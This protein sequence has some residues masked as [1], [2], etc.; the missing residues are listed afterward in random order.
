[1][2]ASGAQRLWSGLDCYYAATDENDAD[3]KA[4]LVLQGNILL[5]AYEQERADRL[6]KVALEPFPGQYVRIVR[7]GANVANTLSLKVETSWALRGAWSP[8]RVISEQFGGL[9]TRYV[10]ALDAPLFS[11]PIRPLRLG[12]G[13]PRPT[14]GSPY[15]PALATLDDRDLSTLFGEYDR[16]GG[17]PDACAARNWTQFSDRMKFIVNLFRAGQQDRNLYRPLPVA[18][19]RTLNLDLSDAH[20]NKLRK[21]GDKE[22]DDWIRPHVA[23]RA[24]PDPRHYVEDLVADGFEDLLAADPPPPEGKLPDWADRSKLWAGQKFFRTFGLEVGA[25][26]FSASLPISY[27]AAHGARVL[28]TT[29]ALVSDPRRRLAETGQM[30]LDAMASD[31]SSKPPLDPDTRAFAAAHGVRLFHGAVRH[32]LRTDPTVNW[33]ETRLGVPIN[34]EDLVGTLAVFT[35]AVI[36]SLDEMGVTVSVRDRDNYFHLWLVMGHLLGIDYDRLFRN[37]PPSTEQPLTY[38]DMQLIAR[39]IFARN[40]QASP[41]GRSLMSALLNV[42]EGSMPPFLK[43]V[44]RALTR[45]LIGNDEADML[46][47]PSAGP[48]RVFTAALRPVN[49]IVSP[50]LRS[51]PLGALNSALTRRLYRWWIDEGHGNR[52]PW[53]FDEVRPPWLDSAPT[54]VRRRAGG[55]VDRLPVV[56]APAKA[57]IAE[58]VR[59]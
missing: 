53:R 20:L 55:V 41:G 15:P 3:T 25:A 44:P 38:A 56:P 47:V 13:I 46:G 4:E 23:K 36:E 45:R 39:V 51:N 7:A 27:T 28:T 24:D 5:G 29:A 50:Y 35:V 14:N 59:P 52:P 21:K 42:T 22:V 48:M 26:L 2:P 40:Q 30:L 11:W 17:T 8:F 37:T 34:Q 19:L 57:R 18:D 58:F 32:M 31:D 49:A 1:M 9:M 54:R 33:H 16:S 10:M 43:G 12:H 6:L